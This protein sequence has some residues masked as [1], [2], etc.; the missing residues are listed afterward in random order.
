VGSVPW[1]GAGYSVI[2]QTTTSISVAQ[3]ISGGLSGGFAGNPVPTSTLNNSTQIITLSPPAAPQA[4]MANVNLQPSPGN[5]IS[6][7]PVDAITG[8]YI[9]EISDLVVGSGTFPHAL[10]FARNYRSSA[11]RANAGLGVGWTHSYSIGAQLTS[12]PFEGLGEGAALNA[13][14]A[15]AALFVSQDLLRQ[16]RTAQTLT[17]AAIVQRWLTDQLNNNAVVVAL[18][19][20]SEQFVR[21]ADGSLNPPVGRNARLAASTG[22]TSYTYQG[23][24]GTVITFG[25]LDANK[26]GSITSWTAPGGPQV[27]FDYDTSGRLA[28][29]RNNLPTPRTL[30]FA[31]GADN[32]IASVSDGSRSVGFA[33]SGSRLAS[34]TD[35][36]GATTTYAYDGENRLTQ[37]FYPSRPTTAFLTNTYD[38]F[39]R[40]Y[41]QL[42]AL[43]Q[44]SRLHFAGSR[45]EVV[46]PAVGGAPSSRSVTYQDTRGRVLLDVRVLSPTFGTVFRDITQASAGTNANIII[47][48]YDGLARV[49]S[50]TLPEGNRTETA[51]DDDPFNPVAPMP[52]ATRPDPALIT[53]IAKPGSGLS[54]L[55]Q[56]FAYTSP[57][58]AR[59]SFRRISRATD[60]R[61]NATDFAYDSEGRLLTVT[62]PAVVR[63]PGTTPVQPVTTLTWTPLGLPASETD[64]EGRVTTHTY[65]GAGNRTATVVDSGTGRLNLR[66][67]W[68]YDAVGNAVSTVPPRGNASG[69]DPEAFRVRQVFDVKRR[70][71]QV[72]QPATNSSTV[73]QY[74]ADDRP[75]AV[76]VFAWDG[77]SRPIELRSTTTYTPTG[78]RAVVTDP[79]GNTVTYAYDG[80]DRLLS[81]TSSSGRQ[82]RYEYDRLSRLLRIREDVSGPLDPSIT[83]NRGNVLRESRSY[84]PNG[85]LA[86]QR[87][88]RTTLISDPMFYAYDGF[89]RLSRITHPPANPNPA[90]FEEFGYDAAGNRTLHRTRAEQDI[91]MAYDTLNRQ[92]TRAVPAN[93]N[94][95]AVTY[96]TGYDL[97]GRVLRLQQSTDG[98]GFV[99]YAYDT[100]GRLT[101][102]TR[103][104]GRAIGYDR[105]ADGNVALLTWP[106]AGSDTY[107]AA[108]VHDALG[109][110]TA[111]HEGNGTA[112]LRLGGYGYDT[113]SRRLALDR[114]NGTRTSWGWRPDG[115]VQDLTHGFA[116]SA[117]VGFTY[118]YNRE[119]GL[120]ARLVSDAAWQ[121]VPPVQAV[122]PYAANGMNQYAT[123]GGVAF[124]YDVNGNLTGDGTATYRYDAQNRL[125]GFTAGATVVS[126]AYDPEGRRASR[127]QGAATVNYL[128]AMGQEI[129]EYS[130]AAPGT[131]VARHVPGPGLDEP[132]ATVTGTPASRTRLWYHADAQ[133]SV[134]ARSD[135][136]GMLPAAAERY[137]YTPYG[138]TGPGSGAAQVGFRWL[139]RRLEP[140]AP[141]TLYDM[142][143]RAYAAGL[144]RFMQTDPIGTEGG[145]NLYAYARNSP[146]N[147][148][149]L[150]GLSPDEIRRLQR[151]DPGIRPVYPVETIIG[152]TTG[153]TGLRTLGAAIIRQFRPTPDRSLNM[154]D[155][156]PSEIGQIQSVVNQ[157]GRP[158][159]VV[160]SAARGQ[161]RPSSD[162]DYIAPPSSLEYFRGLEG[163]LP[164]IDPEHGIIPGIGNRNIGP[165]IRF[166]PR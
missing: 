73:T 68:T 50:T 3:K 120:S 156:S 137:T 61:S 134:I 27:L 78:Q 82:V 54:N 112:G 16:P 23:E 79:S 87:S 12:D 43:G 24:D 113:A 154:G 121:A 129:A 97:V 29:V 71:I 136:M 40:T 56:R 32:N 118:L 44:E 35:P 84:T 131:L 70:L 147:F 48:A 148:M 69:A 86:M 111:I 15:I 99:A 92:L 107:Q 39:G 14:A 166:E 57:V 51:Y 63:P 106:A 26:A 149:D 142:R 22:A 64:A 153:A 66:T 162:I 100:A 115:L 5:P 145:L 110:V 47:N 10:P 37:I 85:L 95:P 128:Y 77:V 109:Q 20:A 19:S 6:L 116:G 65:D 144:G 160:G 67:T 45:S 122:T 124:G 114:G 105:D 2:T 126:Y 139:G 53:R 88:Y 60:P 31:Y 8:A 13:S 55:E 59:P 30:T 125:V 133:G 7:D 123:V 98:A 135:S 81:A 143:A 91:V 101:G 76:R 34:M 36:L 163:R 152:L 102:E 11:N 150:L 130:G 138:I 103:P 62:Q 33:Y 4:G 127:T 90:L 72:Y 25:A 104:D 117:S 158:I 46:G 165:V 83:L 94:A 75:V 119:G 159:E 21:L 146:L 58:P 89:D 140:T 74:D 164:R 17:L 52:R 151:I 157:A 80:A 41:R 161:R 108:Y 42:N 38:A 9:Y 96:T 28:T 132:L 141:I 18:P 155:L 93:A 1:R 49:M